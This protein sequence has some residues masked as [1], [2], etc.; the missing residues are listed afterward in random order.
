MIS[1]RILEMEESATLKMA[2]LAW[3]LKDQGKDVI[4]L[5]LGEPDFDTPEF[6]KAAGVEAI[7][8][9]FTHYP[10]VPGYKDVR[11]SICKKFKRDN[12]LDFN[13]N[14][15]VISTQEFWS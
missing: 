3:D 9:N 6:A 5:S 13:V 10:P 1:N 8:N 7:Q 14:N 2:N 15:I 4:S 11:E 12:N